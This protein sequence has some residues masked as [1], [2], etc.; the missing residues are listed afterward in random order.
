MN[1]LQLVAYG[2]W[3]QNSTQHLSGI[4]VISLENVVD[5]SNL[6]MSIFRLSAGS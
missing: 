2:F 4:S 1:S 5:M 6:T 3:G